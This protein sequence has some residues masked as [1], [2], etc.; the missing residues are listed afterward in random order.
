MCPCCVQSSTRSSLMTRGIPKNEKFG[1]RNGPPPHKRRTTSDACEFR[2][3]GRGMKM[4]DPAAERRRG[5]QEN[6]RI[7]TVPERSRNPFRIK[8][9]RL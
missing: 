8:H 6:P 7:P 2:N 3:F 5:E 1:Q 4:P 9:L